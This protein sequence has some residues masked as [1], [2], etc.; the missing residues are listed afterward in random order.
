MACDGYHTET[1]EK[2]RIITQKI[3]KEVQ[4]EYTGTKGKRGIRAGRI[5]RN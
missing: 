3:R 2:R 5:H 4:G 1:I